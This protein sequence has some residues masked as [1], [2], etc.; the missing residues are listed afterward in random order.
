MEVD[1][2]DPRKKNDPIQQYSNL[3]LSS[4][5]CNGAKSSF[6][7]SESQGQR[8]LRLLNPCEEPDYGVHVFE[9]ASTNELVGASPT[10]EF[11]DLEARFE[12]EASGGGAKA[13][14][15]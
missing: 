4:R 3:M 6:W 13:E 8:G 15:L 12:C 9:D 14:S 11:H 5:H 7:P 10:G 1:H 2:F